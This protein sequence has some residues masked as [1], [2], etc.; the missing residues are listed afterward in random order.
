MKKGRS[1][2]N[3]QGSEQERTC[4]EQLSQDREQERLDSKL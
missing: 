4:K 2:Q 1:E 3:R